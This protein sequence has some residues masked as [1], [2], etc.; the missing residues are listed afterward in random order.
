VNEGR[1]RG[2]KLEWDDIGGKTNEQV[3]NV[4]GKKR[5]HKRFLQP[6][7]IVRG[8]GGQRWQS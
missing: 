8:D 2:A 5:G 3:E 6:W 4:V 7:E 1:G